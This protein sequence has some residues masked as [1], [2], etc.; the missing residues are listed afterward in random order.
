MNTQPLFN[1]Q[2]LVFWLLLFT[3]A[4]NA[5]LHAQEPKEDEIDMLLDE[6]F[7]N[8]EQFMNDILNSFNTN[9]FI[10]TN[11]SFN[12]NTFFTGRDSGIDQFNMVPQISYYSAS[13]FNISVSGIYYENFSPNW[14]FTNVS[15]G[16][17]NTLGQKKLFNYNVGY[18]RY[19][20]ANGWDVFTNSISLSLGVRNKKRTLGTK[21]TTSYLFGTDQSFQIVSRSYANLN[22]NQGKHYSLKLRP[23]ISFVI[24]QQTIALEQLN[25]QNEIPTIEYIYNDIFDL[26]NTQI[27]IPLTLITKSWDFELGYNINFPSRLETEPELKTTGFVNLSIGYLIDFI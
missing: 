21:L 2:V 5:N 20:Y 18:T 10:Y 15:V 25:T 27:N 6:L 9:N 12:S 22:L 24:A 17:Y 8:D 16:Y 7:F 3:A 23:Q 11:V 13:G 26:L 4:T 14:D 1:K 19:F